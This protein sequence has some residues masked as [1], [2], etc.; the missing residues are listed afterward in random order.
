MK[1]EVAK[2]MKVTMDKWIIRNSKAKPTLDGHMKVT[3]K[4]KS[5]GSSDRKWDWIYPHSSSTTKSIILQLKMKNFSLIKETKSQTLSLL[6]L[7]F[8][9]S[10]TCQSLISRRDSA[11]TPTVTSIK[12]RKKKVIW[13]RKEK[14]YNYT[15]AR[16]QKTMI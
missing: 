3:K 2:N 5:N 4:L 1:M 7:K 12:K 16:M 9:M 10:D 14:H 13:K 11:A 6:Y 8:L 15:H